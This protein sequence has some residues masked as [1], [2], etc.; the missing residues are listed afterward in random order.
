MST[1]ERRGYRE[2]CDGWALPGLAIVDEFRAALVAAGFT[3]VAIADRTHAVLRSARRI[4][5]LGT[6]IG[7]AIW[8]LHKVGLARESKVRHALACIRQYEVLA[9]GLARYG[10]FTAVRGASPRE[11]VG[12]AAS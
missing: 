7:P 9:G 4:W 5:W 1:A 8:C 12:R 10:V 6:T 11:N 3:Q 2:W